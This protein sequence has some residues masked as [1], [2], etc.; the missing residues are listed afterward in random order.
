MG[1]EMSL[2]NL[3]L[4]G[5]RLSRLAFPGSFGQPPAGAVSCEFQPGIFYLVLLGFPVFVM[6]LVLPEPL[7]G[8]LNGLSD[9]SM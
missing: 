2:R 7:Q 9:V 1:A 3:L 6:A 8:A 4:V 5:R